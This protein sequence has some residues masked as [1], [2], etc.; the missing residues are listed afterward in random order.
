MGWVGDVVPGMTSEALWW[1]PG[2][3]AGEEHG[4]ARETP[5]RPWRGSRMDGVVA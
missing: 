5:Q 2:N 3:D 1:W 4:M